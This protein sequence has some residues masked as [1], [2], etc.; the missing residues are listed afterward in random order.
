MAIYSLGGWAETSNEVQMLARKP[1][2]LTENWRNQKGEECK[3]HSMIVYIQYTEVG[4]ELTNV[5]C[6]YQYFRWTLH[7]AETSNIVPLIKD[8]GCQNLHNY[9]DTALCLINVIWKFVS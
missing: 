6:A 4:V 7:P 5:D 8:S 3:K 2:L 1:Y 9:G